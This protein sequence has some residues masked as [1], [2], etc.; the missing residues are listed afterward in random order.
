M[1]TPYFCNYCRE[2]HDPS[3]R[4]V[5]HVIPEVLGNKSLKLPDVCGYWNNFFAASFETPIIGR[6]FMQS[7]AREYGLATPPRGAH[8]VEQVTTAR[9]TTEQLWLINGKEA[10]RD[11]PVRRKTN[12]IDFP[13][14]D[15]DG[16]E[17]LVT[18]T[19]PFDYVVGTTGDDTEQADVKAK[20]ERDRKRLFA[21]LQQLAEKPA[22]DPVLAQELA[23]RQLT[24]RVPKGVDYEIQAQRARDTEVVTDIEPKAYEIDAELWSKFY[25]KIGWCFACRALG[26]TRLASLKD[27]EVLRLLK[28]G[29]VDE[30]LVRL[31]EAEA[32]EHV[33][34]LF[35]TATPGG[36]E[37]SLWKGSIQD[38]EVI[39]PK[40][41]EG[42]AAMVTLALDQRKLDAMAVKTRVDFRQAG[43]LDRK[44]KRP[45]EADRI[46]R[47]RLEPIVKGDRAALGCSVTL[48]GGVFE[49]MT[50]LTA[51]MPLN[52]LA[53]IEATEDV[54]L[55]AAR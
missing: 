51:L 41:P 47:L 38:A 30:N 14:F 21:Y 33:A 16:N 11:R 42:V 39:V 20:A 4:S 27:G 53:G 24:L 37:V 17:H 8:F 5:E 9:G 29:A 50:Q 18:V 28:T 44:A 12:S 43:L 3:T 15:R 6:N 23:T 13:A 35:R 32:P 25:L 10:L 52:H 36:R 31:C 26:A 1:N 49:A 45:T 19:L 40:L 55:P 34:S 54:R 46:H 2:L 48:F 7:V 22:I